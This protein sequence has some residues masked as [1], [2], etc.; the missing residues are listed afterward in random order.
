MPRRAIQSRAWCFTLNNYTEDEFNFLLSLEGGDQ[1][2]YLIVGKEVGEE[3]T[4]HLQGYVELARKKT[5]GGVKSLLSCSRIHLEKRRGTQL[6]AVDYCKKDGDYTEFGELISQGSRNDLRALKSS[7]DS[8]VSV[9]ELASKDESFATVLKY[10]KGLQW[11]VC[12]QLKPRDWKSTVF[13]FRGPTGTGKTKRV[14]DECKEEGLRPWVWPGGQWFDG[15]TGQQV[16]LFD[17]FCGELGF[18]LLLRL[19]DRYPMQVPVKGSH[20]EW[21]PKKIYIT[22]NLSPGEWYPDEHDVAP[23]LRRIEND[24]EILGSPLPDQDWTLFEQ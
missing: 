10:R 13:L 3:G 4:P 5:L 24:I 11:Y 9:L 15:Y 16:V 12:G 2:Q 20:V 1:V 22:S 21:C 17:D 6:Q 19:L 7:L 14:W 23:L 18:R 8:G